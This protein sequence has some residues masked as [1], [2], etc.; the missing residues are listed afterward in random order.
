MK[1]AKIGCSHGLVSLKTI[2][3]LDVY[4]ILINT[5]RL[6]YSLCLFYKDIVKIAFKFRILIRTGLFLASVS[7][8][9]NEPAFLNCFMDLS[10]ILLIV[11]LKNAFKTE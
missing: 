11:I 5:I 4:N 7:L 2:L 9:K 8:P 1:I 6:G 3:A 10:L